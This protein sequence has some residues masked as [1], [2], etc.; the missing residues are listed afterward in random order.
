M[1]GSTGWDALVNQI[2]AIAVATIAGVATLIATLHNGRK[3][4]RPNG[5]GNVVEMS[6]TIL[7]EVGESR[8]EVGELRGEVGAL[9]GA[10]DERTHRLD[11]FQTELDAHTLRIGRVEGALEALK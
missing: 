7:R 5:Q 3:I 4:G 6:E 11:T 8:K 2:G 10:F 9:K 1:I